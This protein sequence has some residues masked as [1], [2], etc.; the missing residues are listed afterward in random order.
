MWLGDTLVPAIPREAFLNLRGLSAD[1]RATPGTLHV[2]MG[3]GPP[4]PGE[5]ITAPWISS[6]SCEGASWMTVPEPGTT[7]SFPSCLVPNGRTRGQAL[8]G[9]SVAVP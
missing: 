5:P 7:S 3:F 6:P 1:P 8:G 4:F 9:I 2:L